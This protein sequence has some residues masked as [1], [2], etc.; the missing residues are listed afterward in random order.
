M[1]GAVESEVKPV[2]GALKRAGLANTATVVLVGSGARG[3]RNPRSDIDIL[4][5]HDDG[6]RIRLKR[7]GDIHLQQVSRSKFLR[8]LEKGDDYPCWAL[9]L[10]VPL[11]DP[12]GWWAEQ[13]ATELHSP[14]WPDWRAKVEH[15]RKRMRMASELLDTGDVDAASEEFLFAASHLARATLLRHG[16]FPLSRP[17]LPSQIDAADPGLARL[18]QRLIGGEIDPA[19]L[20]SVES[21]LDQRLGQLANALAETVR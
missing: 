20:R 11:H 1:I 7:P 12:D 10:G 21:I 13:V 9:R 5:L 19:D 14:H 8:R 4:V 6:H 15:A 2:L 16:V 3:V 17:E 18:L